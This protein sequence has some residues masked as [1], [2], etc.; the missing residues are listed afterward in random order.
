MANRKKGTKSPSRQRYEKS[1]PVV[2]CRLDKATHSR[3]TSHLKASGCSFG[4][5][6]RDALG[7]EGSMVERRVEMLAKKK[8]PLSVEER[9]RCL[10]SLMFQ[11]FLYLRYHAWQPMCPHCVKQE[12][13]VAWGCEST[14]SGVREEVP[15]LRCPKCGYFLD[16]PK[17]IDSKSLRWSDPSAAKSALKRKHP[18]R[19]PKRGARRHSSR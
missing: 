19:K 11:A 15:T 16:T 1:H 4:D 17:G 14:A 8:A 18:P 3:L 10:E 5:F 12:M 9:V 13:L 2:S 7:R 6:V